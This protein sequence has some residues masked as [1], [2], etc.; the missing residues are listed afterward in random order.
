M[1]L[2]QAMTGMVVNG[3]STRKVTTITEELCGVSFSKSMV[4][5]LCGEWD[6][7]VTAWNEPDL[8]EYVHP[9]IQLD[10]TYIKAREG[11]RV[12]SK[13]CWNR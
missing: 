2:V 3:V 12:L 6:Q 7:T 9:F 13:C 10:W 8:E 5:S 1:A 4:S 11:G